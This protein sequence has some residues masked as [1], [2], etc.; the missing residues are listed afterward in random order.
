MPEPIVIPVNDTNELRVYR[1]SEWKGLDLV[2]VRRFYRER[3]GGAMAPT[4][5]GITIAYQR[6]PEL[7]EALEAVRDQVPA[8]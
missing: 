2:H 7:I 8:P 3:G 4:S 6:L 1:D 5:K